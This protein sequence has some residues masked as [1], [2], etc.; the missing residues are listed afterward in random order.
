M[1]E[2]EQPER[3][4]V[5]CRVI[6]HSIESEDEVE[7]AR[8]YVTDVSRRRR[9]K[10]GSFWKRKLRNVIKNAREKGKLRSC[11][12]AQGATIRRAI[13]LFKVQVQV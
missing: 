9:N 3:A 11:Y 4:P 8:I 13:M 5:F 7:V 2:F 6:P 1:L 10:C 12:C